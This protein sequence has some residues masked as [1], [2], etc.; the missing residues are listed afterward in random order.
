MG[1]DSKFTFSPGR[2]FIYAL[3][4]FCALYYLAPLYVM[5]T[6]SV[7][8][9]D[10][11]RSGNLLDFP[12]HPTFDAWQKPGVV[13]VLACDVMVCHLTSGTRSRWRCLR[14]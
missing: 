6:T 10:E 3:L 12:R 13:H 8:S 9:L 1:T 5:L 2:I 11:I 4:I 7:K 14:Y